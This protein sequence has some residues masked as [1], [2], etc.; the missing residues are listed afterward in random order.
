MLQSSGHFEVFAEGLPVSENGPEHVHASPCEGDDGLVVAFSLG[1]LPVVEGA[2]VSASEG[3]ECGLVED[4]FEGLVAAG[5]AAQEACL[6]GLA[7]HRS[8]AC[9]SGQGVGAVEA[10]DA[11][12]QGDELG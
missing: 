7:Q 5:C 1:T 3:G 6:A 9:G 4:A 12:D 2:A 10:V 11:P 8:E